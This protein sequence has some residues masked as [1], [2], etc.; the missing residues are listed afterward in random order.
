MAQ[1]TTLGVDIAKNGVCAQGAEKPPWHKIRLLLIL[2][3]QLVFS[4]V[5]R[6]SY[7]NNRTIHRRQRA[8][9]HGL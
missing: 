1:V 8:G 6:L 4:V 3:R 7:V 9:A 2:S 5:R